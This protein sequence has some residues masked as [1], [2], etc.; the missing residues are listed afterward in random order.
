MQPPWCFATLSAVSQS[1]GGLYQL[2]A[3]ATYWGSETVEISASATDVKAVTVVG[4]LFAESLSAI[5]SN[6]Q[7]HIK[8]D[9]A[10]Q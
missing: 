7:D 8:I 1:I 3:G 5:K 4:D 6:T 10:T 2:P 9:V